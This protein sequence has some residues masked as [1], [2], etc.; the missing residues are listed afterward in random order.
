MKKFL[1]VVSLVALVSVVATAKALVNGSFETGD[2]TGWM[3]SPEASVQ[4]STF[5]LGAMGE[6]EEWSWSPTAGNYFAYLLTNQEEGVYTLMSQSFTANVGDTL[7]FDI[8]FDTGD[9]LHFDDNGYAKLVGDQSITLYAQSVTTV[10][11]FGADGWTHVSYIFYQAG[12]YQLEFGVTNL[13]DRIVSSAIGVDNIIIPEPA[14]L[15]LLALGAF[16]AG[17]KRRN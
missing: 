11:D 16:L 2:L 9:Y 4:S 1:K 17:R 15:S 6:P 3:A 8:F 5:G 14:T 7:E 12:M 10:G 13:F